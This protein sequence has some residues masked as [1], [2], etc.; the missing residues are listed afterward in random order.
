MALSR[1]GQNDSG[2]MALFLDVDG[3]L[4]D[5]AASPE[6]AFAPAELPAILQSA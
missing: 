4:I 1:A 2:A 3:T 6:A 5:F